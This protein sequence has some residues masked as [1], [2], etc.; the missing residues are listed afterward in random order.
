MTHETTMQELEQYNKIQKK[1]LWA[2][3]MLLKPGGILVYSTCTIN[4][5]EN[6]KMVHFALTNYKDLSLV[7]QNKQ[8]MIGSTGLQSTSL[9]A[10]NASMVQRFDPTDATDTTGF[11]CAKFQKRQI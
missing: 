2:A 7:P 6:E 4:P 9:S 11:F 1:L 10:E 3:V 5:L 8:F